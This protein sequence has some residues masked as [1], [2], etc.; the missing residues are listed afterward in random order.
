MLLSCTSFCRVIAHFGFKSLTVIQ[1]L[2]LFH[3]SHQNLF[4]SK[5]KNNEAAATGRAVYTKGINPQDLKVNHFY[6]PNFGSLSHDALLIWGWQVENDACSPCYPVGLLKLMFH[7]NVETSFPHLQ[8][9][10]PVITVQVC[11][12]VQNQWIHAG[13]IHCVGAFWV[14][15][16]CLGTLLSELS[17]ALHCIVSGS[18]SG[19]VCLHSVQLPQ[20][21]S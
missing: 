1:S 7:G 3:C 13:C 4:P 10:P 11:S 14:C 20:L 5:A 6:V 17:R 18:L 9:L 2:V 16:L 15:F 21:I 19:S 8:H 12:W